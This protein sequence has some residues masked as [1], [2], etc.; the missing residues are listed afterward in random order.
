MIKRILSSVL[1]VLMALPV[2]VAQEPI[3]ITGT[4]ISTEDEPLP[5]ATVSVLGT[6]NAT[7]TDFDGKFTLRV[8]A[9]NKDRKIQ[10]T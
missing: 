8:P 10:V 7:A 1:L 3:V 9:S 6:K 5:G 4:V 2:L